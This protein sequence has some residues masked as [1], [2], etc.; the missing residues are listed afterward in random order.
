[1]DNILWIFIII[2]ILVIIKV[3]LEIREHFIPEYLNHK[4]KSFD[5]EKYFINLYGAQSAW[6][7]Q[8]TKSFSAQNEAV[9]RNGESGGFIGSTLKFY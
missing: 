9:L 5:D 7:G 2:V 3:L 4:T 8:P 6:R 1:M